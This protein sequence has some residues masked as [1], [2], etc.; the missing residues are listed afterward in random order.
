MFDRCLH[1]I[2]YS[3]TWFNAREF[4]RSIDADLA[5]LNSTEAVKTISEKIETGGQYWVGLHRISWRN[6]DNKGMCI[7]IKSINQSVQNCLL[8]CCKYKK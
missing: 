3:L 4:C 8:R 2:T 5:T 7:T 6:K 1:F